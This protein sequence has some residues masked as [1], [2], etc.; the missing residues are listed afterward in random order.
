MTETEHDPGMMQSTEEHQEIPKGEAAVMPVGEPR[1]RRVICNLAVER[2][3]KWKER[4]R[5]NCEFRRKLA[6]VCRKVSRHAKVAWRER[7]LF[8]NVRT[9]E[10]C[11][12]RKEFAAARIR[13]TRCAKVARRKGHNY[14][15]PS[16]EQGR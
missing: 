1:K 12:R 6:V 16:V 13:T 5:R 15:G 10:K 7:S 9:L 11:G 8:R 14:E 2:H 4:T 3:Q